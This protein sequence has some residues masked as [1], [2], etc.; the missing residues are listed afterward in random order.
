[1][2]IGFFD[3]EAA[4]RFAR[5]RKAHLRAVRDVSVGF[6]SAESAQAHSVARKAA[7]REQALAAVNAPGHSFRVFRIAPDGALTPAG[8]VAIVICGDGA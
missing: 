2:S 1:M 7:L 4:A 6:L 8:P 3:A 5:A